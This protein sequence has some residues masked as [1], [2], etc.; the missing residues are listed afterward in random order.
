MEQSGKTMSPKW[1]NTTKIIVAVGMLVLTAAVVIRFQNIFPPLILALILTYLFYPVASFMEQR[2]RMP[3]GLSVTIIYLVL[4]MI[5]IGLLI[6]GGLEI[7]SQ[8]QSFI[9]VIQSTLIQLTAVVNSIKLGTITV[10]KFTYDL[11]QLG[12]DLGGLSNQVI[13]TAEPLLGQTGSLIGALAGSAF[14]TIGWLLFILIVSYFLLI[15]S[16]GL[17]DQIFAIDLRGYNDD[18]RK[19][20]ERLS[21]IWNAFLRGQLIV[22][23]LAFVIYF[24]ALNLLGIRYALGLALIAGLA[25]FLPYIGPTINWM[26]LGLIAYFQDYKLFGMSPV[27]YALLVIACAVITDYY[28]DNFVATRIM[29]H[30]LKVH[31]AAIMV[32]VIIAYE[33]LGFLGVVIAAPILAT[34]QLALTYIFR[35]L[36]DEDPW[37]PD[38]D[39]EPYSIRKQFKDWLKKIRT[40]RS[41]KPTT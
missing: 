9:N 16:G 18:A 39:L 38:E 13:N 30:T 37:P 21:R 11:S 33:L 8:A 12:I 25:R 28:L 14:S 23:L 15:E 3:W 4:G 10:G 22:F 32:A 41:R 35:K 26:M 20:G 2:A 34:V 19:F 29:S 36:N 24:I 1:G 31:A 6:L 17:R 27:A 7:V 40:P 5:I